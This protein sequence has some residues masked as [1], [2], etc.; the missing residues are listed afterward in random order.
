MKTNTSRSGKRRLLLG[1]A[2]FALM[3]L[4]SAGSALAHPITNKYEVIAR[5]WSAIGEEYTWGG[6]ELDSRRKRLRSGL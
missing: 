3:V 1:V 2:V 4:I 5:A 6:R